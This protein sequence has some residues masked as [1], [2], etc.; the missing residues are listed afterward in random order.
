M[1]TMM[2]SQTGGNVAAAAGP[3]LVVQ[4]TVPVPG[5]VELTD[6]RIQVMPGHRLLI[7]AGGSI[8]GGGW[9]TG[10]AGPGGWSW[11]ESGEDFPMRG[12]HLYALCGRVGDYTFE[13]GT[14][15]EADYQGAQPNTLFLFPQDRINQYG[16][17]TGAFMAVVQLWQS[18]PAQAALSPADYWA[19]ATVP[20]APGEQPS[21]PSQAPPEM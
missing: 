5:N 21:G 15:F 18:T 20:L 17:N 9:L 10:P 8:W 7:V 2:S 11:T 16:N 6:T 14:F 3:T 12:A 13:V 19:A 4:R 1:Q